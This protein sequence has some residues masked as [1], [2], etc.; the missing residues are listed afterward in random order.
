MVIESSLAQQTSQFAE[1]L[2]IKNPA[3]EKTPEEQTHTMKAPDQQH[4]D[5][6]SISQEARALAAP[7]KQ[8]TSLTIDKNEEEQEDN[9]VIKMLKKQIEKLEKEIEEL[10]E[11]PTLSEK[12]KNQKIMEKQAQLVDLRD[13]LAKAQEEDLKA[14]GMASGG[15]TRAN[16]FG[17]SVGTF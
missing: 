5:T 17:N 8:G 13:Q 10:Q 15:G 12:E 9:P 16:G 1:G 2:R 11:D 3:T 14:Q 6:I 7:E 4:G